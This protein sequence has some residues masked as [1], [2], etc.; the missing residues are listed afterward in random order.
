MRL[1]MT[2]FFVSFTLSVS[3]SGIHSQKS[4]TNTPRKATHQA[5][6]VLKTDGVTSPNGTGWE[7]VPSGTTGDIWAIDYASTSVVWIGASNGDVCRSLDGGL[8]FTLCATLPTDGVFGLAAISDQVAVAVTGPSTGAAGQIYR[9]TNGG[10]TWTSVYA[11]GGTA[12]FDFIGKLD[13]NN[14]WALSDP[15]STTFLI[16]KST[17]AYIQFA[18]FKG[19][20]R[21]D[22]IGILI[23]GG[24]VV[25]NHI[26]DAFMARL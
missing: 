14:L 25:L 8:T 22:V 23:S 5:S 24:K 13:A 9:T 20:T 7:L 15:L 16:V 26:K 21:F 18:D 17:D 11:P 10:T 12:W 6:R 3:F 19:E 1:L 4:N 2:L